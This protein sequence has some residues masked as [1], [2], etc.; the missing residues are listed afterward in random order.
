MECCPGPFRPCAT[1]QDDNRKPECQN[2]PDR[3][4]SLFPDNPN[5]RPQSAC[6]A[7]RL[8]PN[9]PP[10]VAPGAGFQA[11]PSLLFTGRATPSQR[12]GGKCTRGHQICAG[13]NVMQGNLAKGT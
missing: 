6:C 4:K 9:S 2:L 13:G 11:F 10:E 12:T 7:L 5:R 1:G 3:P 8:W